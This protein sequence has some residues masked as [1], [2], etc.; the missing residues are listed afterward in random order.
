MAEEL[1]LPVAIHLGP[2][3][4][5]APYLGAPKHRMSL[6]DPLLLE[7]VLA[8]HPRL[9]LYV[10]HAGWP[11]ADHMVALMWFPQV[12]VDTAV[13]DFTQPRAE[14]W[15]YL[16]HLVDAGYGKRI[17]FGSDQMVWPDAVPSAI[18]SIRSAP[19]RLRRTRMSSVDDESRT[20]SAR[21]GGPW[22]FIALS[23]SVRLCEP[24]SFNKR[25]FVWGQHRVCSARRRDDQNSRRIPTWPV[26][27]PPKSDPRD[28][29]ILPKLLEVRSSVGSARLVWFSTFVKVPS[30]RRRRF[31]RIWK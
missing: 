31:S 18:D 29:V 17:M 16:K 8:K 10:M 13:I 1:D 12:Y 11:M 24:I 27:F 19:F 25:V 22:T 4:P 30:A 28:W 6:G 15:T 23:L 5:G 2:G 20:R 3:P 9:R 21:T 26:R 7:P 14:F